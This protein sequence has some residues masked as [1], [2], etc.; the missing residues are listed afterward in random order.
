MTRPH[1]LFVTGRLAEGALRAVVE[2]LSQQ[3]GFD[4]TIEVLPIT[5]AAL[6]T[7]DWIAKRLPQIPSV[8]RVILPGYTR[9]EL[10]V[11]ES[12]WNVTV[13]LGPKDLRQLP[14]YFGK[15]V[16]SDERYGAYDIEIVAEINHAP[17]LTL[18]Q[19]VQSAK[20]LAAA[21]ANVIDVGCD[22]GSVWNGVGEAVKRLKDEGLRVSIDS[23]HPDEIRQAVG[24]G[25]E[26]VL[27]LNSS[28]RFLAQEL[29][30]E[31][32]L[33]P[34]DPQ[35]MQGLEETIDE[36]AATGRPFRIDPIL[37]PIG[38]GFAP[39]LGR[40][41]EAR[42]RWPDLEIMMGIGN[43]T[44]LTDV[45][46]AGVNAILLGFCQELRIRSVLTTQVISWAQSSVK[47]CDIA[48]RLMHYACTTG[49]PPKR[50][51]ERLIMLRDASLVRPTSHDLEQ[52]AGQLTDNNYRLY[53]AEGLLH[54]VAARLHVSQADPFELFDALLDTQPKNID[55]SHAF[56]LGYELCKAEIALQLGK[57]YR[58]DESLNWGFLT[59]TEPDRHRLKKR[60]STS[61][62]DASSSVSSDSSEES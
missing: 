59:Q 24:A 35:N 1:Y 3:V 43:L 4:A 38:L 56:Y 2:R 26:L 17:R 62:D 61:I 31:F 47:E 16:V 41:L 50:I 53:V 55:A 8:D 19:L 18:E 12:T 20:A 29:D 28:N 34:D 5:V 30:C 25:A 58:Q 9:G 44:E 21:G 46:S 22:P 11:L 40:Y 48:R 49:V 52:L 57:D 6:L 13:E 39:S 23:L 33:I 36:V 27:S 37:E 15:S 45:D 14:R 54:L 7:T 51:E 42:K 32:V 60:R 10:S